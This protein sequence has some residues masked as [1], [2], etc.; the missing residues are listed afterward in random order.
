MRRK[1]SDLNNQQ[2]GAY[3]EYFV[4][5][6]MT[7]Y[8]FQVYG[9]EVDDRGVDFV[10]RFECGR[11]LTIQ[12]KAVR[13][14]NYVFMRKVIF[15]I[16]QEMYL[17]L[18]LLFEG[19]EPVLYLIPSTVWEKPNAFFVDRQYIGKKSEPEWGVNLSKKNMHFLEPYKFSSSVEQ[20]KI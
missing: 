3:A 14:Y 19:E 12:V 4:K 2:V 9:T 15:P 16:S 20:L 6:E 17:A 11:F 10:A 18:A 13:S 8:G 5:M 1:W 7:M